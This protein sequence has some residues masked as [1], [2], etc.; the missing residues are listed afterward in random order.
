MAMAALVLLC[1]TASQGRAAEPVRVEVLSLLVPQRVL[2]TSPDATLDLPSGGRLAPGAR[3]ELERDGARVVA[4]SGGWRWRGDRLVL[5]ASGERI[6]VDVRGRNRLVR[7]LAGRLTIDSDGRALRLVVETDLESLVAS[8]VAAELDQVTEP[9]ALEAAA[10]AI[11]SYLIANRGRHAAD[12]FD[13]CDTTHCVFSRGVPDPTAP[14]ERA[15]AAAAVATR[16]LVLERDGHVVAGYLTA[17]CGGRTTT[18]S[19]LWNVADDGDYEPVS[20]SLCSR[21]EFYR[22]RRA[23]S[24][25]AVADVLSSLTG[26]RVGPDA[27]LRAVAG[28]GGWTRWVVVSSGGRES[29]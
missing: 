3:L 11:R 16:G 27:D 5:G 19:E 13:F 15:A 10:I 22:W 8:A 4:R 2:V 21:S 28:E 18:P 23:A 12:G 6:S 14:P 29:R 17:C 25:D 26:A 9:A 24:V 1:L 7:T 20:C